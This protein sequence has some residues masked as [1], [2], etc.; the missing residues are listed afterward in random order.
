MKLTM[1]KLTT[2][3]LVIGG[4]IAGARAAI[5][6]AGL[7]ATTPLVTKGVVGSGTSVGPVVCAAVG[8]WAPEDDS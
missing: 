5:E 1:E 8:P 6:A 2:D 3:V 7:G 4:G